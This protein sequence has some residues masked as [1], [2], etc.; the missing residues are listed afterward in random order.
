MI[1][2][3]RSLPCLIFILAIYNLIALFEGI[4]SFRNEYVWTLNL[5]LPSNAIISFGVNDILLIL[6]LIILFFE[7]FKSTYTSTSS[8]IEH[9]LSTLVFVTFIVEFLTVPRLG[10]PA[11]L[12]VTIMAFIDVITGFTVGI[13]AGR[14]DFG[15]NR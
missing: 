6:A 11:F 13:A 3:L 8:I 7:I 2:F 14:R 1:R 5:R 4:N 10:T 9:I 15:F 12:M